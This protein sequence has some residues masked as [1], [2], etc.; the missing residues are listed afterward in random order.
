L[1]FGLSTKFVSNLTLPSLK[2]KYGALSKV[3]S[4]SG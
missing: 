3:P 2:L 1:S 4:R